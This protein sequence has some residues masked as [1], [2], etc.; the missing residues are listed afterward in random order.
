[1][2]VSCADLVTHGTFVEVIDEAKGSGAAQV[3]VMED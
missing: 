1:V 3:A 2:V